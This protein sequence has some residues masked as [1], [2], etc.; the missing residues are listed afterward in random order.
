VPSKRSTSKRRASTGERRVSVP[1]TFPPS[2]S[3]LR[4]LK[5]EFQSHYGHEYYCPI[6]LLKVYGHTLVEDLREQVELAQGELNTFNR[7]IKEATNGRT[8]HL[9]DLYDKESPFVSDM[10]DLSLGETSPAGED[11]L[12]ALR[13]LEQLTEDAPFQDRDSEDNLLPSSNIFADM[14]KHSKRL[15]CFLF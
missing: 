5:V 11:V 15:F 14:A 12:A 7:L 2:D 6:T 13:A 4:Y 3:H 8:T 9:S 10:E 1:V